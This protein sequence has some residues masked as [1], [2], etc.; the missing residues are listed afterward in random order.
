MKKSKSWGPFSSYQLNSTA[1][2]AHLPWKRAKLHWRCCLAV[3][4]KMFPN[5]PGCRIIIFYEINCYLKSPKFLG[6]ND[7]VLAIVVS[8]KFSWLYSCIKLSFDRG[9]FCQFPFRWLYY[10][11]SNWSTGKETGK[12]H[13]CAVLYLLSISKWFDN[14][15]GMLKPNYLRKKI[16]QC[17]TRLQSFVR[18]KRPWLISGQQNKHDDC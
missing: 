14:E 12:T 1:N 7:W 11:G 5:C 4:S 17:K 3:S 6:Y 10:Y 18:P 15:F 13:L 8:P 2:P 16:W 9:A